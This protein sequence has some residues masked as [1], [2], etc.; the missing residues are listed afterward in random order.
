M[1]AITFFADVKASKS[2]FRWR[3]ALALR[4]LEDEIAALDGFQTDQVKLSAQMEEKEAVEARYS[5]LR[6]EK[7]RNEK[8]YG[9]Q[10]GRPASVLAKEMQA[11]RATLVAL[12]GQIRPLV[13]TAGKL[14]NA[15][16]GPAFTCRKRQKSF[17]S[18]A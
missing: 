15:N 17:C 6:L 18:P 14:V 4:S 9:P 10:S 11:L 3:T 5:A 7:L 2:V 16:W 8:Q 13:Q 12:D 1:W